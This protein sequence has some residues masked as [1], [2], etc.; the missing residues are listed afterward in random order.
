M[1]VSLDGEK[2]PNQNSAQDCLQMAVPSVMPCVVTEEM[3]RK[4]CIIIAEGD[5]Y[6]IMIIIKHFYYSLKS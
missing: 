5:H 3:A 6:I 2:G 4:Y 1:C